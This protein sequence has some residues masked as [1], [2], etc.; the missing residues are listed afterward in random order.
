MAF[1]DA[2]EIRDVADGDITAVVMA[3]KEGGLIN[4]LLGGR[5]FRG[6]QAHKA[7]QKEV[8]TAEHPGFMD[9][10][11]APCPCNPHQVLMDFSAVFRVQEPFP[12]GEAGKVNQAVG[13]CAI[14][15]DPAV[16]PRVLLG[17]RIGNQFGRADQEEAA[18]SHLKGA[19]RGR[20]GAAS[21]GNVVEKVVI[22]GTRAPGV[23]GF[24]A[25]IAGIIDAEG[26]VLLSGNFIRMFHEIRFH[27][28][29]PPSR[30]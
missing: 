26:K 16:Y 11:A 6:G 19:G 3:D 4:V 1:T 28:G 23:A 24:A 15:A 14:E 22:P 17:S 12:M 29:V 25:L 10:I 2:D 13:L 8:E 27:R 30:G 20:N 21:L 7:G 5:G 9:R 18:G